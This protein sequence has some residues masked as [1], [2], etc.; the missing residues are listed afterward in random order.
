MVY[1][2]TYRAFA[3]APIGASLVASKLRADGHDV[4][5]VDLMFAK[6][7]AAEAARAAANFQPDLACYSIRNRDNQM[8]DAYFD[9][10][11]VVRSIVSAVRAVC[12]APILLG[13]TAFTTFPAQWLES[14]DADYGFAG[15]D[16]A[17]ISR[18]AASLASARPD[19]SVPGLVYRDAAGTVVRNPFTVRGY[20]DV[21]FDNWDFLDLR[22]YRRSLTTLWDAALVV[23]TGCPFD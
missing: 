8:A 10:L 9:P 20:A 18:F 11:P 7:P 16:L 5:F 21:L 15:D 22:S 12:P 14:L 13:G 2:N 1:T 6:S 3:P 19:R 23:R 17:S 4:R